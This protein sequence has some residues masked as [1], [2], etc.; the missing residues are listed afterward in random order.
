MDRLEAT[1]FQL[2]GVKVTRS[3]E[4]VV[5]QDKMDSVTNEEQAP[6]ESFFCDEIS[7]H[8]LFFLMGLKSI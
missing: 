6:G 7:S 2:V 8:P 5:P 3:T 4:E 1:I